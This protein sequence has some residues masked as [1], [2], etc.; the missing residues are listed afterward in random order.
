M[1][2][3]G[4]SINCCHKN[5]RP[6]SLESNDDFTRVNRVIHSGDLKHP[7]GWEEKS[8]RLYPFHISSN[9]RGILY[10]LLQGQRNKLRAVSQ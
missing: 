3:M 6:F 9:S 5:T 10:C 8:T 2:S 7:L 1:S 4:Y